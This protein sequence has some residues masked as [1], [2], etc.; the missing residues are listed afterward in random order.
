VVRLVVRSGQVLG[1]V[2][3]QT[4]V[5]LVALYPVVVEVEPVEPEHKESE[6]KVETAV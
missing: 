4:K 5:F 1:R 2:A 3:Q 6:H